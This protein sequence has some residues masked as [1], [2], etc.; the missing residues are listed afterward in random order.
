MSEATTVSVQPT[1][2]EPG[3]RASTLPFDEQ[4]ASATTVRSKK[5]T[6]IH[7]Y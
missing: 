2:G 5:A 1:T 7:G 4:E 3:T 6:E